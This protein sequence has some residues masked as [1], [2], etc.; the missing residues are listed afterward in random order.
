MSELKYNPAVKEALDGL[1]LDI[2][3]VKP[4]KMFG[5]PAY[6]VSGKM[7]A[8]VYED[9]VGLK[10]PGA[11]AASLLGEPG[12]S[13]FIPLGR[14]EMKE[15]VFILREKPEQY[16]GDLETLETSYTYVA[17]LAAAPGRKK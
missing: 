17:T 14:R 5:Y 2:P 15:W 3:G 1:L 11:V 4:G 8:C 13:P 6:Y 7:F 10:L 12:I 9:G 16:S